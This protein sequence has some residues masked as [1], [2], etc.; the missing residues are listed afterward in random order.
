MKHIALRTM[1]TNGESITHLPTS[2]RVIMTSEDYVAVLA[3]CR[4]HRV[5]TYKHRVTGEVQTM[6]EQ[7]IAGCARTNPDLFAWISS[8]DVIKHGEYAIPVTSDMLHTYGPA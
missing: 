6:T 2:G 4:R 5:R 3:T 1:D 7:H 8:A